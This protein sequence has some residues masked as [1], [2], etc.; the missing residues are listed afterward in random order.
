MVPKQDG[1]WRPCGDYRRLNSVTVPDTYP[2]PNMLDFA[3]G[4]A[5][6]THFSRIDLKKGYHQVPMNAADVPKTA[7]ITPFGLFEYTRMPFGL[8]NAGNTFQRLIDRT[9]SGVQQASPYLDDILVYSK[10]DANH[11][12]DL[13]ETFS[14]LRAANLTANVEKCEFNKSSLEFLG[15]TV[16]T[17]GIA[18]L[19]ARVAAIAA[20]PRPKTVK[21]L[22]NF[23][24]VI[25]F[26]RKFVRGAAVILKP[27]SDL[28][29][30]SPRPKTAV[31]W[32]P[33][34]AAAFK[35]AKAALQKSTNLAYPEMGAEMSLMVDASADHV[36]AALQQRT[37]TAAAWQPLGFFSKKLDATQRRYS[38]YDRELL[39]C[40]MGIRHFRFMLEGRKFTLYTDHK[41][42][43]H[44]LSKAAEAWTARQGRHLSYIAE[45]TSDIRHISGADNVVADTLS[46]PPSELINAVA[47]APVQVDYQDI[48][49]AQRDCPDT[50][51]AASS[52]TTLQ[53]VK[54]GNVELLCDT[55]GPQPRPHIPAAHRRQMFTAFHSLAHPGVKATGRLM[56]SRV[57]WPLMKRDIARWV[58]DCQ[59]CSRAKVT[60]QPAAAVQP[61]PV[62]TQRFTH[63]HVDF[64]G[65]LTTSK[66][67]FRYLFTIIDRSSRWLEAIPLA[68]MD[69]DT[70]VE[71]LISNWVAR[72]GRPA[73]ITSD[74][75]SQFTSS[76][77]A[78]TCQQLGV[79]HVTTTAY[80]PQ[81]NGMVERVHRHLKEGLKAR[82]AAADWPQHLPWVLLNIRTAPKSDSNTSAAEM[83]YGA[84]LTLPAQLAATEETPAAAADQQRTGRAI[85]TRPTTR[86]PPDDIPR[87]LA[88]AEMV[89]VRKGGQQGPLAPP[90]SGPYRVVTRNPKYFTIQ[91]GGQDQAVSV[92]RLKPHTGTA[93][94]TAAA[95]PRRGRPPAA[96]TAPA[97]SLPPAAARAAS[98]GLPATT[99]ARPARE[100]RP[101]ARLDL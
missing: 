13:V 1:T 59:D 3:A 85:P 80:H 100:R 48:A 86:A 28:L 37:R 99:N 4:A 66:E 45:F 97:P 75:G 27:L 76:I 67:G 53:M 8:R 64:V 9:L 61:I 31:H 46:R 22:Q 24:G 63:I 51:T 19:P 65:P 43:T 47:A 70:C 33:E 82:G 34:R 2:L 36:G 40:V 69:T 95:P 74:R 87:H 73:V 78:A 79:K 44:A 94:A 54:F 38:A 29:Q 26:Y 14:R 91:I 18:P 10:G 90:Y 89:Y 12:R 84:A 72:F 96:A 16:S 7:I 92:D 6:C 21:D 88:A 20:H 62:P 56:G 58:A 98:P 50:T 23:L 52:S 17:A 32:T 5:G 55:S 25:N 68:S 49:A 35:A 81:S 93:T 41:P 57:V 15:H 71:A 39:A 83:V 42:L 101:P 60:R 11:R 30:G 77:W